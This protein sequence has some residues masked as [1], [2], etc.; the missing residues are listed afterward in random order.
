MVENLPKRAGGP[1]D[2]AIRKI[3]MDVGK[4]LVEYIEYMYPEMVAACRSWKSAKVSLRNHVHNDIMAAVQ[5]AEEGRDQEMLD[6]HDKHR[7]T[8]RKLRKARTLEDIRRAAG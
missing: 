7:R 2:D 1:T 8:M 6:R 4:D 3:A 5:A